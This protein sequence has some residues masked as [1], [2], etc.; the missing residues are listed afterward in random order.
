MKIVIGPPP[1]YDDIVRAFGPVSRTAYFAWGETIYTRQ[2]RQDIDLGVVRHE[3]VHSQQQ[4]RVGGPEI[5]WRRYLADPV[6]RR[7]QEIPAY[8][9]QLA[10]YALKVPRKVLRMA[11]LAISKEMSGPMYGKMMTRQ[12]AMQ[13]LTQKDYRP[14]LREKILEAGARREKSDPLFAEAVQ[15]LRKHRRFGSL[16]GVIAAGL[17]QRVSR[18]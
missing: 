3:S 14:G 6:F 9:A 5:W 7:E 12:E 16:F 10:F 4:K 11:T 1:N 15:G 17:R 13:A 8:R 2:A 18:P